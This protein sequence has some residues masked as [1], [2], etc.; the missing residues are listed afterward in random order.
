MLENNVWVLLLPSF[1]PS[2]K[3]Q[4]GA[5]G[6]LLTWVCILSIFVVV[7][8]RTESRA[9]VQWSVSKTISILL[10]STAVPIIFYY[11]HARYFLSFHMHGPLWFSCSKLE[12]FFFFDTDSL[13]LSCCCSS[14][15]QSP[16]LTCILLVKTELLY[17]IVRSRTG[18]VEPI[19]WPKHNNDPKKRSLVL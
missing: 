17:H 4:F 9:L 8:L 14:W 12:K 2:T 18:Q 19:V 5:V 11:S 16:C 13:R 3:C 15:A 7:G 10:I 6:N 1:F